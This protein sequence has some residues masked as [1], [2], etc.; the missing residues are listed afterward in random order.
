[1][2]T[3]AYVLSELRYVANPVASRHEFWSFRHPLRRVPHGKALRI[4]VGAA[5]TIVWSANDWATTN[6]VDTNHN[7]ALH[8]WYADLPTE[9]CADGSMIQFSFLWK[10]TGRREDGNFIP[11]P[12][13]LVRLAM[14]R[15]VYTQSHID[16]VI[17]VFAD[18]AQRARSLRG[19]RLLSSPPRLA[20]F[21]AKLAP[22][23]V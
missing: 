19:L 2:L 20:H 11:A 17:E 4:I 23:P 10:E 14:P 12:M 6:S 7:A 16:F 13:E 15:R 18:I 21:T 5:A 1:M 22:E 3:T 8:L 9:N